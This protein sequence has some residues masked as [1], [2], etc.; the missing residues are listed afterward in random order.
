[1]TADT[2]PAAWK[3]EGGNVTQQKQQLQKTITK[4]LSWNAAARSLQRGQRA[5]GAA[6][7]YAIKSKCNAK[8]YYAYAMCVGRL[9]MCVS[10]CVH[11]GVCVCV[12][13]FVCVC[14]CVA[15]VMFVF[16][17][18]PAIYLAPPPF[19][20]PLFAAALGCPRPPPC[21]IDLMIIRLAGILFLRTAFPPRTFS[22]LS[23]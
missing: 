5:G 17:S 9:C 3:R 22:Q 10:S 20:M 15:N 7:R 8:C 1:M 18:L 12:L 6:L 11:M 19:K 14:V 21:S 4:T 2:G 13:V 23:I 16:K